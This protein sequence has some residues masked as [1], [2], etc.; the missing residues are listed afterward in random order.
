VSGESA[1]AKLSNNLKQQIDS[2]LMNNQFVMMAPDAGG[3]L[4]VI[5]NITF[6]TET[7]ARMPR[8]F[9]DSLLFMYTRDDK[10]NDF[11]VTIQMSI[12]G[13]NSRVSF[14]FS[15]FYKPGLVEGTDFPS[16]CLIREG[17]MGNNCDD[18]IWDF[19]PVLMPARNTILHHFITKDELDKMQ[20]KKI[21]ICLQIPWYS[22][23]RQTLNAGFAVTEANFQRYKYA[24]G[25]VTDGELKEWTDERDDIHPIYCEMGICYPVQL[26]KGDCGALAWTADTAFP[27][28]KIVGI[29]VAGGKGRGFSVATCKEELE[30]VIDVLRVRREIHKMFYKIGKY[31]PKKKEPAVTGTLP[32]TESGSFNGFPIRQKEVPANYQPAKSAFVKSPLHGKVYPPEKDLSR[33]SPFIPAGTDEVV[34]PVEVNSKG[35]GQINPSFD[36]DQM[37]DAARSFQKVM[38]ERSNVKVE[39]KMYRCVE[40][41]TGTQDGMHS[42][43]YKTSPG[44]YWK[45]QIPGVNKK[46]QMFGTEGGV[47]DPEAKYWKDF[48]KRYNDDIEMM[49]RGERVHH[50]GEFCLKDERLP[51]EKLDIKTRGFIITDANNVSECRAAFGSFSVWAQKNHTNNCMSLGI[52]PYGPDWQLLYDHLCSLGHG[53]YKFLFGD[54]SKWDWSVF[55]AVLKFCALIADDWYIGAPEEERRVRFCLIEDIANCHV[56]ISNPLYE[57]LEN[58]EGRKFVKIIGSETFIIEMLGGMPSGCFLTALFNSMV[59]NIILRYALVSVLLNGRKYESAVHFPLWEIIEESVRFI[60]NGD[61]NGM[62]IS[63]ELEID[64]LKLQAELLK[65][66]FFYTSEDKVSQVGYK[67]SLSLVTY[68]KRSFRFEPLLG[69]VVGPLAKQTIFDMINWMRRNG[70]LDDYKKTVAKAQEEMSNWGESD[71]NDFYEDLSGPYYEEFGESL[72]YS[73]WR[74]ALFACAAREEYIL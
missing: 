38:N 47:V 29:H 11:D 53:R 12:P 21:G 8:H 66:G 36:M 45:Q 13:V 54:F 30:Q 10:I 34:N 58:D 41:V 31:G 51:F 24:C 74:S 19:G 52:N 48:E 15:D 60:T 7:Y 9:L 49:S 55:F 69:R 35:F 23:K 3:E 40:S 4:V 20:M 68:L 18:I 73:D 72:P 25:P 46:F 37:H 63:D 5:G 17:T 56:V 65:I 39:R 42:L 67:L 61:D 64:P 44:Y 32:T 50:L 59:N 28:S 70:S 6:L 22:S 27:T 2:V 33:T 57:V 14:P 1:S 62:A 71:W 16:I 26:D 43:S